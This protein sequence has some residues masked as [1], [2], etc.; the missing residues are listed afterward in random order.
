MKKLQ[1]FVLAILL[2]APVVSANAAVGL[3]VKDDSLAKVAAV[4]PSDTASGWESAWGAEW[5][6]RSTDGKYIVG[7]TAACLD[8]TSMSGAEPASWNEDRVCWCT[9]TSVNKKNVSGAWV[10]FHVYPARAECQSYCELGC[11]ACV[12]YGAYLSCTRSALFAAP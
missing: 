7:G 10:L 5:T 11:A 9:V 4:N 2:A 8:T 1:L 6:A 12:R 3:C